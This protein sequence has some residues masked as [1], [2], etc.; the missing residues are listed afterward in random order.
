M[1]KR[2]PE[3]KRSK[4]MIKGFHKLKVA[5]F[6]WKSSTTHKSYF[7]WKL[8]MFGKYQIP[9][10]QI[11]QIGNTQYIFIEC[12]DTHTFK[13]RQNRLKLSHLKIFQWAN[14][15]TLKNTFRSTIRISRIDLSITS[16]YNFME[17]Q[18][19]SDGNRSCLD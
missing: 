17:L 3:D 1:I 11:L 18:N 16:M 9:K 5:F 15:A 10:M 7:P 14:I 19:F 13:H 12:V 4:K 8:C 2:H 6:S